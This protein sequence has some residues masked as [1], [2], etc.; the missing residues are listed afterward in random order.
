MLRAYFGLFSFIFGRVLLRRRI[1][2]QILKLLVSKNIAAVLPIPASNS[3]SGA[4]VAVYISKE[5]KRAW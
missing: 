5:E 2:Y 1:L 4:M 3:L